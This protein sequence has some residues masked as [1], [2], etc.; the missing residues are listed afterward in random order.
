[1]RLAVIAIF[2]I[3]GIARVYAEA[4]SPTIER[5]RHPGVQT[6]QTNCR[7]VNWNLRGQCVEWSCS[8]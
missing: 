2:L 1:M 3:S 7:C 8:R 5:I 6:A 4:A